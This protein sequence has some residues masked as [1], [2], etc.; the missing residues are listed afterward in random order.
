M[1]ALLLPTLALLT[2][3]ASAQTVLPTS[4]AMPNGYG[5]ANGG[6]FNYWDARYSGSGDRLQDYAP[7]SGG[8]GDLTDGVIATQRWEQVE[9]LDGTGPYVGWNKGE[10]WLITFEFASSQSFHTVTVWHDD[11]NG[12]GDIAPPAAFTVTVGGVTQRFEVVDPPGDAPF[13]SVLTLAPG[14]VG[15]QLV[16]G[17]ERFSNGVMLSE[18]QFTAAVP[19]PSAA[20]L[21]AAGLAALRLRRGRA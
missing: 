10:P 20:L 4:Y 6:S 11:A 14:M 13:A 8:L 9:N 3:G 18:V 5:V 1:R 12:F 17:V 7:L 16:L 21:L 2:A 19:E 15:H